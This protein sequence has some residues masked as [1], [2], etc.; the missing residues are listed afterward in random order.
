M[1]AEHDVA[2]VGLE[3]CG[4]DLDGLASDTSVRRAIET[5]ANGGM[6]E[7]ETGQIRDEAFDGVARVKAISEGEQSD[8]LCWREGKGVV[9]RKMQKGSGAHGHG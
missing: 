1:G 8:V 7:Q 4:G 6:V 5:C 3:C 2:K 9:S